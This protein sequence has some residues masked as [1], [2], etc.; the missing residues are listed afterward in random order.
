MSDTRKKIK[1]SA[2]SGLKKLI[3]IAQ[4]PVI[5]KSSRFAG[6]LLEV[7]S[8]VKSKNGLSI[9][10]GLASTVEAALDAFEVPYP[11]KVEQFAKKNNL[12]QRTG[13][14]SKILIDASMHEAFPTEVVFTDD[15][16]VIKEM[17]VGEGSL[18]FGEHAD[19]GAPDPMG[20]LSE[21][22]YHTQNFNFDILFDALWDH[23]PKGVH[24]SVQ[25]AKRKKWEERYMRLHH[26]ATDE[27]FYLGSLDPLNFAEKIKEFREA[28]VSRS[29]MLA[30][31]P[32]TGKSSF[33]FEVAHNLSNKIMKIDP[34]VAHM[35]G[36]SDLDFLLEHLKPDILL[37]DDFDRA[38]VVHETMNLLFLLENIK[39]RF[40]STVV[41]ATVNNFDKL[42]K[43]IVRPGRFDKIIWFELPDAEMRKKIA[44]KY[45]E[46]NGVH[47]N[48]SLLDKIVS[49]SNYLAPAYIKELCIRL[50]YE[51]VGHIE[52][53]FKEFYKT[54]DEEFTSN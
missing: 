47:Y 43:A 7:S 26:L 49:G 3:T 28:G 50:K 29:F 14:L 33:V 38:S 41:F 1:D 10:A 48:D 23:Y 51:G 24:V 35:L 21:V 42:D 5:R 30:G 39:N 32:G 2:E 17:K 40:P 22:Y 18:Y 20:R 4:N 11:T 31:L 34:S 44:V 8:L 53:I 15:N 36:G 52:E 27:Y 16:W 37:F 13:S 19:S 45:L 46:S 54:V 6:A 25:N 9:A 12:A